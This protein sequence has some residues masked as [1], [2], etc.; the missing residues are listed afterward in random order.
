MTRPIQSF[1]LTDSK[2]LWFNNPGQNYL[3]MFFLLIRTTLH[4]KTVSKSKALQKENPLTQFNVTSYNCLG[5]RHNNTASGGRRGR[6]NHR[7]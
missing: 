1:V 2:G 3:R 4:N 6:K 7:S 5:M